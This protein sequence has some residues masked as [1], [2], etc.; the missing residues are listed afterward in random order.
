MEYHNT[1]EYVAILLL[2]IAEELA[3]YRGSIYGMQSIEDQ[4]N[5][6]WEILAACFDKNETGIKAEWID[7]YGKWDK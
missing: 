2:G 7:K 6:G 3:E 4:L 1:E 5:E